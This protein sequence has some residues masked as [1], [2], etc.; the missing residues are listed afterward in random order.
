MSVIQ[1]SDKKV[2]RRLCVHIRFAIMGYTCHIN[3][4]GNDYD[5]LFVM[6]CG[7]LVAS[8]RTGRLM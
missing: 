4:G 2:A 3:F 7:E 1:G 5:V 6:V 8:L